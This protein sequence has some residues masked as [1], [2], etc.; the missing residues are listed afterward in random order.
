[1]EETKSL[2]Q[3]ILG[4]GCFWCVEAVFQELEG[5]IQV[6][7]GY[8][9]GDIKNP[10]YRE[11]TSGLTGHAEVARIVFDSSIISFEDILRVFFT[12][13]NPT[14]LNR[15]GAD[16]GTQYRSVVFY[17]SEEQH[18]STLK[19]KEEVQPLFTDPIVTEISKAINYYPAEDYH[20]NF[21]KSNQNYGYCVAVIDPKIQKFR[22]EHRDKLRK[23]V[24]E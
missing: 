17:L 7:S 12:T 1:M 24:V 10:A 22:K 14:T 9:G 18:A 2:E 6:E 23:G 11:V 4:A 5:V 21:Y 16:T 20:Q 8:S 15:Q 3:T 19:I 13:H